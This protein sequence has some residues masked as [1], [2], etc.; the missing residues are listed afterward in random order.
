[1]ACSS[2]GREWVRLPPGSRDAIEV[3][4]VELRWHD[5]AALDRVLAPF[6][7]AATRDG[8]HA[9]AAAG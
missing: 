1:M 7:D 5:G 2:L 4:A 6:I 3:L 9:S 8:R